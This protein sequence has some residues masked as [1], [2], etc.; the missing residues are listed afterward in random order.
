MVEAIKNDGLGGQL[1]G[2]DIKLHAPS[3]T[4]WV[5]RYLNSIAVTY[6]LKFVLVN[7][8]LR[9]S[10]LPSALGVCFYLAAKISLQSCCNSR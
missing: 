6:G 7:R 1:V 3:I 5:V 2:V 4:L 9:I 8:G 10:I